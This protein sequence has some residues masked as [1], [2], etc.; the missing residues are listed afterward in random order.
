[1]ASSIENRVPFLTPQLFDLTLS[2]P[3]E[4]L[5]DRQGTTKKILREA[6]RGI[7]PDYIFARRD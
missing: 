3:E 4:Y 7:V 1:M 5:L 6:L 2:L